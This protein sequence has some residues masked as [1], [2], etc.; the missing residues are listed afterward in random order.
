MTRLEYE[1]YNALALKTMA[2]IVS[3]LR[4]AA[5]AGS[6]PF[7]EPTNI[8][9]CSITHR[10]G[11]VP[12]KESSIAVIV[13]TA[14]RKES[15]QACEWLLEQVKEKVQVWKREVYAVEQ[16]QIEEQSSWKENF[17]IT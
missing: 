17:P 16:D 4:Q 6:E 8:L 2:T 10:L 15:F 1:A 13:S 11:L 12:P 9:H 7:I 5:Q 3:D 14:H